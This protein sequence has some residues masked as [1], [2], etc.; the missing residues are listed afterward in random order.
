[1]RKKIKKIFH[2]NQYV[3]SI[4][5]KIYTQKSSFN[6]HLRETH[7]NK[8]R[9]K[10]RFCGLERVRN[11]DHEK[12]CQLK[13]LL[14]S[15]NKPIFQSTVTFINNNNNKIDLPK[16]ELKSLIDILS[17]DLKSLIVLNNYLLYENI[18]IGSVE[19]SM[20]FMGQIKKLI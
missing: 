17:Q 5:K 11:A 16:I 7:S 4:C 8:N 12:R 18:R 6:R 2:E 9:K 14:N 10:C 1:M 19:L 13:S 20:F 3:C 15:D